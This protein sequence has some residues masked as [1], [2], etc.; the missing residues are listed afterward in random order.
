MTPRYA[1]PIAGATTAIALLALSGCGGSTPS[2]AAGTPA[3]PSTTAAAA[4]NATT[5]SGPATAIDPC[6]LITKDEA[7]AAFG[8]T[9]DAPTTE[10]KHNS[11]TCTY[12]ISG[13]GSSI[14][15]AVTPGSSKAALDGLKKIY[16][17]A[18]TDVPGV[19]DAAMVFGRVYSVVKGSTLLT[20]GTGDGPGIISD[21]KLLGLVKTALS[22]I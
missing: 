16:G 8:L 6:T 4:A 20:V 1:R 21:D 12:A 10:A 15:I 5:Q 7:D 11:T 14:S 18:A 19:G 13:H 9:F 2:A 3:S 22:R 17:A